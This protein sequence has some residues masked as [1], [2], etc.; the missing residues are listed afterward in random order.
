MHWT[1]LA[2]AGGALVGAHLLRVPAKSSRFGAIS[3]FL[4]GLILSA[5]SIRLVLTASGIGRGTDFDAFVNHA[6]SISATTENPVILFSGASFSRNAIDEEELTARLKDRGYNYSVVS[7]SLEAAS[8]MERDAHIRQYLKQVQT[9]PHIIFIETAYITDTR[10]TFIFGNS[11]FSDRAIEQFDPATT[12]WAA[13]GLVNGGC[14]GRVDCAKES[15][16]LSL[17]GLL[18]AVNIGLASQ[19][20]IERNIAPRPA[21]DA[22][23][24]ARET[25]EAGEMAFTN[26]QG[27]PPAPTPV[28]ASNQRRFQRDYLTDQ[29]VATIGYYF[30]PVIDADLRAYAETLCNSEL[31]GFTCLHSNDE[32]LMAA[33]ASP[34]VWLDR[35][36]LLAAGTDIYT[37]WL[38]DQ[39]IASGVLEVAE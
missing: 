23:F 14:N 35:E 2:L 27:S 26:T 16:F 20:V 5:G 4:L 24:M 19:G 6:V 25:I 37:S 11:K 30:P 8:L 33:L 12:V 3:M 31:D 39:L 34:D 13:T 1:F 18:N 29:G 36:H 21:Y 7:L 10:P 32:T 38:V 17:H 15:I 9:P 28:W 22:A